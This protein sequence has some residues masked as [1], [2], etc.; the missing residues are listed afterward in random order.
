MNQDDLKVRDKILNYNKKEVSL[1][2]QFYF[3]FNEIEKIFVNRL[4]RLFHFLLFRAFKCFNSF[5]N[6]NTY[7]QLSI[8]ISISNSH[9]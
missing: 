8:H 6:E 3:L 1:S 5:S 4:F 7:K 2:Q 9:L